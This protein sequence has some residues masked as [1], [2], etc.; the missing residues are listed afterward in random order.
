M[1]DSSLP[2]TQEEHRELGRELRATEAR[3]RELCD[4]VLAVY[5]PHNRA[6][7]GFQKMLD[8]LNRLRADMQTQVGRDYPGYGVDGTYL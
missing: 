2:L 4:V 3:L 6:A 5:G 7:F 1:P 8:S